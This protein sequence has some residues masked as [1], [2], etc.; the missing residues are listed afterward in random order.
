MT[1]AIVN[2]SLADVP[3]LREL[4]LTRPA[5]GPVTQGFGVRSVTGIL[6][7]GIDL[8][9]RE[10]TD[11][12]TAAN[13]VVL[14][15]RTGSWPWYGPLPK[16]YRGV[17]T[18]AGGYGNHL[19]VDHGGYSDRIGAR[20]LVTSMYGHLSSVLV[21]PG[22][23]LAAGAVIGR[24][25]STGISTGPHL[26]WEIR[27]NA[28]P[29]DGDEYLVEEELPMDYPKALGQRMVELTETETGKPF[30]RYVRLPALGFAVTGRARVRLVLQLDGGHPGSFASIRDAAG[31]NLCFT[32][33]QTAFAPSPD[34]AG[35]ALLDED[36]GLTI[37][38]QSL[39][40]RR[41]RLVVPPQPMRATLTVFAAA[42]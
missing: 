12:R 26:H 23:R 10:G 5:V 29:F 28:D 35:E 8:S 4:R 1:K 27:R 24:S 3:G 40:L 32:T 42:A 38:G 6:H 31:N 37:S 18:A 21:S 34:G 20:W 7:R 17:D 13:G 14:A 41:R 25:G 9:L 39:P 33:V 36:G 30:D 11:V 19:V 2:G 16:D 22:Q 15:V